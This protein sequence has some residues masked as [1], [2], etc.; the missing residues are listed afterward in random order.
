MVIHGVPQGGPPLFHLYTFAKLVKCGI[1]WM[2]VNAKENEGCFL[3]F[4]SLIF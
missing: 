1:K 3:S 2:S 4:K